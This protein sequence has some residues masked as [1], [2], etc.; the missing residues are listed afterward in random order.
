M[1]IHNGMY[2]LKQA[3]KHAHKPLT[4]CLN[5]Y[6]YY[7]CQFTPGLWWH[8]WR[9]KI[10]SLVVDDFS[11]KYI[12]T[13]HGHHIINTLKQWY[14]ISMDWSG[15]LF[16]GMSIKWD[17]H[18][19][20]CNISMPGY[21]DKALTK[22][23]HQKPTTPQQCPHKHIPI[24]FGGSRPTTPTDTSLPLSPTGIKYVQDIVNTLLYYAQAVNPI[25]P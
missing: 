3:K 6:W 8:K 11:I 17:Y 21:I 15:S 5:P 7:R 22:Y 20:T 13:D 9:P 14:E 10:F 1:E 4:Q 2:G 23:Q 16:C 25:W 18:N 24:A 19:C 12:G